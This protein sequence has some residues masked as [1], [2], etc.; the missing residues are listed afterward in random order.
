M[1]FLQREP[2]YYKCKVGSAWQPCTKRQICLGGYSRDT[3]MAESDVSKDPEY[4]DNWVD[5]MNLLCEPAIMIGL[6][7]FSFFFGIALALIVVPQVAESNGKKHIF[8][9]SMALSIVAQSGLLFLAT[10][11]ST[12]LI[13][14]MMLGL[15]WPGKRLIG[16]TYILDFF[17]ESY[18]SSRILWFNLFDYPSILLFSIYYQYFDRSWY[19]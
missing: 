5:R 19:P 7:G 11:I 1:H 10:N 4:I 9:I 12:A 18:Q 16:Y 14:L 17:P 15:A 8:V 13:F 2:R 3:Y 6:L